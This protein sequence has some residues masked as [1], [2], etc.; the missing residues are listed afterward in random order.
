MMH[1]MI[2]HIPF[3]L[4]FYALVLIACVGVLGLLAWL[5]TIPNWPMVGVAIWM[6]FCFASLCFPDE[7][8][9]RWIPDQKNIT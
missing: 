2:K 8:W 5:F 4:A 3:F 7:L 9:A 1:N 6:I